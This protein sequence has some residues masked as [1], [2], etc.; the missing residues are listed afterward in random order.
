MGSGAGTPRGRQGGEAL[1]LTDLLNFAAQE[2]RAD[3]ARGRE[4]ARV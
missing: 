1:H 4:E 2:G 3:R